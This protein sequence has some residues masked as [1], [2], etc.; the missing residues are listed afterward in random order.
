MIYRK[1]L[2]GDLTPEE[3]EQVSLVDDAMLFHEFRYYMNE[4]LEVKDQ[5]LLS[6]PVFVTKDFDDVEEEYLKW[7]YRLLKLQ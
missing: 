1:F 5:T 2:G 3:R 7:F 6:K 4:E